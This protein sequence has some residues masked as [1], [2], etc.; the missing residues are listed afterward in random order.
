MPGPSSSDLRERVL[1]ACEVGT[2]KRGE[3]ADL[4]QISKPTLYNGQK[5]AEKD[6]RTTSKPQ[7]AGR[8]GSP[9]RDG[10]GGQ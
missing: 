6:G 1:A 5:Q 8:E 3:I 10:P 9:A 7:S 2:Q 4:F